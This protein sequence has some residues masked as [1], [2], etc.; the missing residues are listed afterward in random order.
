MS[1]KD[2]IEAFFLSGKH[3]LSCACDHPNVFRFINV[4][5]TA[6][7][8]GEQIYADGSIFDIQFDKESVALL[9][10]QYDVSPEAIGKAVRDAVIYTHGL[11]V[12]MIFDS[13]RLSKDDAC[14]MMLDMGAMLLENI[15]IKT[16]WDALI[17]K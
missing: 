13:Y 4:D 1:D 10:G 9:C 16:D 3:Y 7:T 14:K 6:D 12:M 8:I 17:K 11:A 5:D 2:A 15:G